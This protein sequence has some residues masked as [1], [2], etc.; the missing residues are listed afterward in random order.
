MTWY[1]Q[2]TRLIFDFYR[3]NPKELMSLRGLGNCKLSRWWGTFRINCS[4]PRTASDLIDAIDVLREPIAQLRLAQ[5]LKI[6]VNGKPIASF[7]VRVTNFRDKA[8]DKHH[9]S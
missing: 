6:M 1:S 8:P 7:P 9:P 3:E 2:L 5:T 4:D